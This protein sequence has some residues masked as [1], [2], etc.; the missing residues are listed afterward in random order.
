MSAKYS[1]HKQP[2]KASFK[3]ENEDLKKVWPEFNTIH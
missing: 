2:Y 3:K 1:A